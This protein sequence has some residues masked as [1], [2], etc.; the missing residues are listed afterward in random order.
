[1]VLFS[2]RKRSRTYYGNTVSQRDD[3][4]ISC[5]F[6]ENTKLDYRDLDN[7]ANEDLFVEPAPSDM[8]L[9]F[10]YPLPPHPFQG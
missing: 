5:L 9:P 8:A 2:W 7:G 3:M 4:R 10:H 1:M 6:I